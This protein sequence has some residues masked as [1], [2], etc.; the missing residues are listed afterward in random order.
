MR[1]KLKLNVSKTK[2]MIV[3]ARRISDLSRTIAIDGELKERVEAIK[4]LGV[5]L[6]GKLNFN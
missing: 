6:D 2:C 1:G 5:M 3:T 4:Y